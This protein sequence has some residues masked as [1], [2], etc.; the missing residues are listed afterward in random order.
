VSWNFLGAS[1]M[2]WL[3]MSSNISKKF[4]VITCRISSLRLFL[5]ASLG[6]LASFIFVLLESRT[7]YPFPSFPY[8]S[9]IKLCLGEEWFPSF[10]IFPSFHLVLCNYVLDGLAGGFSHLVSFPWFNFVLWLYWV[11]S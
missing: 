5:W 11:C 2:F 7:G 4:S 10:F 9:C 6:S 1:C 8:E 3:T